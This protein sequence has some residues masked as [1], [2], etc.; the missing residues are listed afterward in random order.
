MA[1]YEPFEVIEAYLIGQFDARYIEG[2]CSAC[3]F[4]GSKPIIELSDCIPS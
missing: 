4:N 3:Q 2:I 1:R